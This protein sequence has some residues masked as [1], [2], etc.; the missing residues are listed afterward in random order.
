MLANQYGK[1]SSASALPPPNPH[2]LVCGAATA[3]LFLDLNTFTLQ[4]LVDQVLKKRL[5]FV[6]P[7]MTLDH[8]MY[9]EGEDLDEE[10]IADNAAHLGTTLAKLPGGGIVHNMRVSVTDASQ[11]VQ[12]TLVVQHQVCADA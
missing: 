9:E 5:A 10:E 11:D 1:L 6:Y 12:I 3:T 2:C 4:D 8:W 7:I